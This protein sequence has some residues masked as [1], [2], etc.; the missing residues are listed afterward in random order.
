M[1]L[2]LKTLPHA[3]RV[4]IAKD[5]LRDSEDSVASTTLLEE[6]DGKVTRAGELSDVERWVTGLEDVFE[7]VLPEAADDKFAD[8]ENLETKSPRKETSTPI[9]KF[10]EGKSLCCM[11]SN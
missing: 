8:E 5:I 4:A 9:P 6:F 11:T 1:V 3:V 10:V 7:P 2:H